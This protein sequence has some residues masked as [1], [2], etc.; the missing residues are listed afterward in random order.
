MKEEAETGIMEGLAKKCLL[1]SK[2]GRSK[3]GLSPRT[4]RESMALLDFKFLV[5]RTVREE[6][7][8]VLSYHVSGNLLCRHRKLT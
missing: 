1:P 2:A 7:A 8:I 6:I 3:E 4:P 5:F